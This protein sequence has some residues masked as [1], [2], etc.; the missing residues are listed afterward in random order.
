MSDDTSSHV[1]VSHLYDEL[2]LL[3]DC[4][5]VALGAQRLIWSSNFPVNDLSVGRSVCRSVPLR[6]I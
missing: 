1:R 5:C 3:L 6:Y 4:G 2:L